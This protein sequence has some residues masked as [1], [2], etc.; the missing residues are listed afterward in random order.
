MIPGQPRTIISVGWGDTGK[1]KK[2]NNEN[3]H[4]ANIKLS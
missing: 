3:E 1:T 4:C 2:N